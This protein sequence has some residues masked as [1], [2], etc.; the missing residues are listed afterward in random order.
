MVYYSNPGQ[1]ASMRGTYE[2]DLS[3]GKEKTSRIQRHGL[4]SKKGVG[5]KGMGEAVEPGQEARA[6]VNSH[7]REWGNGTA[8]LS[9]NQ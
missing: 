3:P 6:E 2:R 5:W 9:L 1:M 4:Y 8:V 7:L